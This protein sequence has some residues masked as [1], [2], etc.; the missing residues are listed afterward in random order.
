MNPHE[1]T[2]HHNLFVLMLIPYPDVPYNKLLLIQKYKF[3]IP[4]F[5]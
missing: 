2:L 5:L 4:D 3:S 1:T